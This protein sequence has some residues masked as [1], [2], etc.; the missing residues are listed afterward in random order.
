MALAPRAISNVEQFIR[1]APLARSRLISKA[2]SRALGF[3]LCSAVG[4]LVG[5]FKQ[6]GAEFTRRACRCVGLQERAQQLRVRL[7]SLGSRFGFASA[8]PSFLFLR[9]AWEDGEQETR[10]AVLLPRFTTFVG[11]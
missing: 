8:I 10:N 9:H 11:I 7:R 1:N 3:R 2:L 5:I 6:V 4:Q